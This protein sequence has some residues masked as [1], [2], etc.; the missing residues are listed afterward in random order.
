MSIENFRGAARLA[1]MLL[2]CSALQSIPAAAQNVAATTPTTGTAH[3]KLG[4]WGIDLSGRDTSVKPGDDFEKYASG[5]WLAR[6]QIAPD[7]PEV[8]AF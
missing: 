5:N 8:S 3:A 6:T 7:K 1:A 2:A 4:A